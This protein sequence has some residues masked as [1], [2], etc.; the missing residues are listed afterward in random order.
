MAK[1]K[2]NSGEAGLLGIAV[3]GLLAVGGFV[4]YKKSQDDAMPAYSGETTPTTSGMPTGTTVGGLPAFGVNASR[5]YGI[6][7]PSSLGGGL[8]VNAGA[9]TLTPTFSS[10][11]SSTSGAGY[12]S[13][14][15]TMPSQM[16][17]Y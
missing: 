2:K 12:G 14:Y 3:V 11:A 7:V 8:V 13:S 5:Y 1:S 4:W 16:F 6:R 15:Y 17:K 10:D 9:G